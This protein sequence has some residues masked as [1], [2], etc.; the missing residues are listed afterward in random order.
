MSEVSYYG[1]VR[2]F[3]P[4]GEGKIV[5]RTELDWNLDVEPVAVEEDGQRFDFLISHAR[6][7]LSCKPCIRKE[8][9][10]TR[11]A[12]GGNKLVVLSESP[13]DIYPHFF[14]GERGR[15][16]QILECPSQVLGRA[17]RLRIY[18][19]GGYDEN[20]LKRY[21]VLY[22][23]DGRNLFFPEESFLGREW[24]IDE[25]LDLLNSMNLI[26]RAIVVG[27]HAKDRL[28]EY[29]APGY[30]PY[31]KALATELKPWIDR[32]LR[33]LPGR[34]RTGV[35]GSS[36][37]GV[38]A[39][40]LAWSYPEVFGN[41]ACLSST[42]GHRDDLLERVRGDSIESRKG[43][44]IYLDSGWPSDNYEITLSMV[45]AL[46]ERGF[47][48]GRDVLHLAFPNDKHNETSWASR[49]HIPL[50][51]FSGKVRHAAARHAQPYTTE[52][53]RASRVYRKLDDGQPPS[54]SP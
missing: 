33:T 12:A 5:L 16:T 53:K 26:D 25:S 46:I 48:L 31:A 10:R 13:Q 52:S 6:P 21:P 49:V 15:I 34:D 38:I 51:L 42:F 28:A 1:Y 20:Y 8:G 39:F 54:D 40:H 44:K 29:T 37:G 45:N 32:S 11:W 30:V 23:F 22:M 18:L 47:M 41:A 50:Q 4:L 17:L 27:V 19:P 2:V 14:T 36:L 43:L 24:K 9:E 3:Y 7:Y 35:M